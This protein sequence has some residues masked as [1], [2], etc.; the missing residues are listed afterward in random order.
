MHRRAKGL[1]DALL[2]AHLILVAA[3]PA[4]AADP[5]PGD[6][7]LS[8]VAN[9]GRAFTPD[10]DGV[11]D[12][13]ELIVELSAP[14][15]ISAD[16]FDWEGVPIAALLP[17]PSTTFAPGPSPIYWDGF[18]APNGAYVVRLVARTDSGTFTRDLQV[19]RV[20][21]LPYPVNPAAIAIFLDAGHGGDA[22][23][24]T[25]ERL[26]DGTLIREEVLNLDIA[27][28]L[29]AMLRASGIRVSLSRIADVPA[30]AAR[31]DRNGEAGST[32]PMT[33]SPGSTAP[34][35][36]GR[37][38]SSRC[39]TIRSRAARAGPRRSTAAS[40]AWAPR[41]TGRSRAPSSTHTWRRSP[42]SRRPSGS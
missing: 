14:A 39:T 31:V 15:T 17:S 18:G 16:V 22:P 12:R 19:A 23:G 13:L 40:D 37:T 32:A 34:I 24:G 38:C 5:L 42:R 2:A 8:F 21:A 30:N 41:R 36:P 28:K 20:A 9:G 1:A 10:G 4:L 11:G 6:P 3:A 29:S 33:T 25:E 26:P 35:A 27:L 7:I